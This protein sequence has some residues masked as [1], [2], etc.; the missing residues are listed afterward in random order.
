MDA[1]DLICRPAK[2]VKQGVAPV[3]CI[4]CSAVYRDVLSASALV[5]AGRLCGRLCEVHKV[6]A[7]WSDSCVCST[8]APGHS[9]SRHQT[10]INV[11][12]LARE[13]GVHAGFMQGSCRAD[14]LSI[15][16]I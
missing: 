12:E 1:V 3:R 14:L 13:H 6:E 8:F 7:R 5:S 11:F 4:E 9:G 10:S 15:I 2:R 16:L